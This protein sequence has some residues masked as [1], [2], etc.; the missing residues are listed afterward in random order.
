LTLLDPRSGHIRWQYEVSCTAIPSLAVSEGVLYVPAAGITALRTPEQAGVATPEVVWR[1][2]RLKADAASPVVDQDRLYTLNS[3]GVLTC[4]D[5]ATGRIGWRLRLK[6][7]FWATPVMVGSRLVLVNSDGLV[8]VVEVS[9]SKGKLVGS[10]DLG[11]PI[12]A[13]P[14]VSG[15]ALYFRSDRHLWKI[16]PL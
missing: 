7:R 8:Q 3:T 1:E 11:A 10:S 5:T 2:S 14:A 9:G 13:S 4:S 6:G 15:G 12:Q 16:A